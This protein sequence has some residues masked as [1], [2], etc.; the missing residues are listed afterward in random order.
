MARELIRRSAAIKIRTS[1]SERMLISERIKYRLSF[2]PSLVSVT[3]LLFFLF[4]SQSLFAQSPRRDELHKKLLSAADHGLTLRV[5]MK[6]TIE[7]E[8]QL[9]NVGDT[10]FE[11]SDRVIRYESVRR[12]YRARRTGYHGIAIG[13][14]IGGAIAAV[15]LRMTSPDARCNSCGLGAFALMGAGAVL[16]GLVTSRPGWKLYWYE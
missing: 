12:V 7:V 1:D 11:V 5:V 6:D 4:V 16:G 13:A 2:I 3:G 9:A 14:A 15:P 10:H 8:G